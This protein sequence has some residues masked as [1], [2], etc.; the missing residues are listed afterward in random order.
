MVAK[1]IG[2]KCVASGYGKPH[3]RVNDSLIALNWNANEGGEVTVGTIGKKMGSVKKNF[4]NPK[5]R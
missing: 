4:D 5:Q 2:D 3:S 1:T